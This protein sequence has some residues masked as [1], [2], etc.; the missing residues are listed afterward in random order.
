MEFFVRVR[1]QFTIRTKILARF[2]FYTAAA[3]LSEQENIIDM[4]GGGGGGEAVER[5]ELLDRVFR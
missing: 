3:V 2:L 1:A 5:Q 4:G